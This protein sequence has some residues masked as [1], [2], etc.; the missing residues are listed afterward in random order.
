MGKVGYRLNWAAPLR[1]RLSVRLIDYAAVPGKLSEISPGC[2]VCE[3][4]SV[5]NYWDNS[6]YYLGRL[7]LFPRLMLSLWIFLFVVVLF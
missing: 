2:D 4:R 5:L 3:L 1:Y 7:I 6:V